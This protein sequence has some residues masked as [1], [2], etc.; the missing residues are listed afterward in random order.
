MYQ[1]TSI[2]AAAV[3]PS[4]S[5]QQARLRARHR[6]YVADVLKA[7]GVTQKR[8]AG[9]A[10]FDRTTLSRLFSDRHSNVLSP[11]V[12]EKI[13]AWSGMPVPSS[14]EPT[15]IERGEHVTRI[16]RAALPEARPFAAN[17]DVDLARVIEAI[18]AGRNACDPFR[19]ET[20]GLEPVGLM[21]G[22]VA[23]VDRNQA[24]V[25]GDV[26]SVQLYNW[27]GTYA[28]HVFRVYDPPRLVMPWVGLSTPPAI[29]LGGN[30][31]VLG[32]VT[33]VFRPNRAPQLGGTPRG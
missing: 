16:S 20:D 24:P 28:G 27:D 13:A 7:R 25:R 26:V 10:G 3:R 6:A 18:T 30:L 22:D 32:P 29:D 14:D 4:A 9:E 23:F 19:V 1:A 15:P 8:L 31:A 11:I 12:L 2:G 5:E 33:Q 17:E 21:R